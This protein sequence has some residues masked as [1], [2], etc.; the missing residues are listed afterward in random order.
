MPIERIHTFHQCVCVCVCVGAKASD[1][2]IKRDFFFL[3]RVMVFISFYYFIILG[4]L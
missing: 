1:I 4:T 3:R 2:T